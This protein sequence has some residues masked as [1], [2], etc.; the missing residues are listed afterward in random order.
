MEYITYK[1]R[2]LAYRKVDGKGPTVVFFPGFMSDME[3][4]KAVALDVF[5]QSRGQAYVRFDYSGHG[6]SG[7]DFMD[8]TI[9]AWAEDAAAIIDQVT[10][11]PLILVGSSMGGWI[12]LL[13]ALKRK[14]RVKAFVGLAA[15]PDFTRE[16]CWDKYSDEIKETLKRDGVYYEA[17]DYGDDPYPMTMTLITEG[18]DHLLLVGEIDLECPVRLIQGMRDPDVPPA[19]AQRLSDRLKSEDVVITYVKNGDH[20]LSTD[21]D[22]KRLCQLVKEVSGELT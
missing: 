14:E 11:G 17:C 9:G 22:L 8:G 2:K 10:E 15:A 13:T 1:D 19:T 6:Q 18:N 5:C 16:L 20:R 7:G 12:G 4:S 3:G 21:A